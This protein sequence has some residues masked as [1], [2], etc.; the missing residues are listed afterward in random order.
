MMMSSEVQDTLP[1]LLTGTHFNKFVIYKF[2]IIQ[3]TPGLIYLTRAVIE[4][5]PLSIYILSKG[6][7]MATPKHTCMTLQI[8]GI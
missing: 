8:I 6:C 2:I 5:V 1:F 4:V 7:I 3:I